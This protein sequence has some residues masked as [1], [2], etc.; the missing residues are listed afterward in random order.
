M[1]AYYHQ[2]VSEAGNIQN[3]LTTVV[4]NTQK[5]GPLNQAMSWGHVFSYA[6]VLTHVHAMDWAEYYVSPAQLQA[7]MNVI[8][9]LKGTTRF[10]K[11]NDTADFRGLS[12]T[13]WVFWFKN[14]C[15][16]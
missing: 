8:E 3:T 1:D 7:S 4:T 6:P 12:V 11:H 2:T 10:D 15:C 13:V 9:I 16:K 14:K 5:H